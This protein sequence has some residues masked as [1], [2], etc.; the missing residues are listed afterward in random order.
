[1][2]PTQ[3]PNHRRRDA[4]VGAALL[5]AAGYVL[6]IAELFS[7]LAAVAFAELAVRLFERCRWGWKLL[8]ILMAPTLLWS[9]TLPAGVQAAIRT[10][11]ERQRR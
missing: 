11:T 7:A 2:T 10:L 5:L 4:L 9:Y 3:M 1:M 8:A 6:G